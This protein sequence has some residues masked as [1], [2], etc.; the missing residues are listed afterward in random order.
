MR[1]STKSST[2]LRRWS[3]LHTPAFD[4]SFAPGQYGYQ[5]GCGLIIGQTSIWAIWVTSVRS[6]REDRTSISFYLLADLGWCLA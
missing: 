2:L 1:M 5:R 3:L 4:W 6:R